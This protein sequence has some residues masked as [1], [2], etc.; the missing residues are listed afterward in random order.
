M[1]WLPESARQAPGRSLCFAYQVPAGPP[2]RD[3]ERLVLEALRAGGLR[4]DGR[5]AT[6]W[7][8]KLAHRTWVYGL[9]RREVD[10]EVELRLSRRD[11]AW[12]L[13]VGCLPSQTHSAHA[14][15][16]A[17]IIVLA[18]T[19]WVA[20]GVVPGVLPAVTTAAAGFLV[21]EVTRQWAFTALERRLQRLVA[22]VGSAIWPAAPAQI[23]DCS[24]P[25]E[26]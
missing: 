16:V 4:A 8:L 18:G 6:G 17:G 12:Q 3:P 13:T 22:D 7:R 1:R 11:N 14:A 2:P 25:H 5:A 19:V 24:R 10:E 21:V 23:V 15:G 20:G 26:P 9:I